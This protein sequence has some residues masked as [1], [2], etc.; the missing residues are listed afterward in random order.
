MDVSGRR[1]FKGVVQQ[2]H[3]HLNDQYEIHG[4]EGQIRCNLYLDRA[5]LDCRAELFQR[6]ADEVLNVAWIFANL[7]NPSFEAA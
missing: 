3:E 6:R 5:L 1:V 7:E 2:I 4:Y